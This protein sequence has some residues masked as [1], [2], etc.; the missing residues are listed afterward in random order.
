MSLSPARRTLGTAGTQPAPGRDHPAP[1][2]L[3]LCD[4]DEKLLL[5][6]LLQDVFG[7]H[8]NQG[9]EG[10]GRS[11][12]AGAALAVLWAEVPTQPLG[13]HR[14]RQAGNEHKDLLE[15]GN[16]SFSLPHLLT[17]QEPS[18]VLLPP[19]PAALLKYVLVLKNSLC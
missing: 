2:H 10:K 7:S 19:G 14:H 5:Q 17:T 12:V 4:V 9:L 16:I 8:V 15:Q 3:M 1:A 18:A 13:S 6:E 11:E